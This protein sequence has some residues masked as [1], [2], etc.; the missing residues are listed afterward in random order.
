M[1][2]I[3]R[4]ASPTA[5]YVSAVVTD[6][7]LVFVSGQTPS[8]QGEIVAGTITEQT[9][10]VMSNISAILDASGATLGDVV[11]CGVF[12]ADLADLPEFN[13][14]YVRAFGSRLPARTAVGANLPGYAV[15]IDCIAAIG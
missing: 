13:E 2:Y 15:E 5:P 7:R 8:R 3:R 11:R 1:Q 10:L 12:L 9:E 6:S 4:G 14:A